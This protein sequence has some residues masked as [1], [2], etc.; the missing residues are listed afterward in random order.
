MVSINSW[1]E[2]SAVDRVMAIAI[3]VAFKIPSTRT[4]LKSPV[5]DIRRS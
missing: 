3:A 1:M 2:M 5:R 4:R